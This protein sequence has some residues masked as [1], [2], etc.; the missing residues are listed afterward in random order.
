MS[1]TEQNAKMIQALLNA[2]EV[3]DY[4]HPEAPGR[5]PVVVGIAESAGFKVSAVEFAGQPIQFVDDTGHVAGSTVFVIHS[6]SDVGT[7]TRV[8]FSYSVE[9]I[10]GNALIVLKNDIYMIDKIEVAER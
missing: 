7:G 10:K 8:D 3:S 5:L 2:P 1:T 6:M 9:G 4:I